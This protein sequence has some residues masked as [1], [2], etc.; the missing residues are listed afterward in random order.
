MALFTEEEIRRYAFP[1]VVESG[2]RCYKRKRVSSIH[3]EG[4][5]IITSVR[6]NGT[7]RVVVSREKGNIRFDCTCGFS[8]GGACEHVVASMYAANADGAIQIGI[9]WGSPVEEQDEVDFDT[10]ADIESWSVPVAVDEPEEEP[11]DDDELEEEPPSVVDLPIG[12]PMG[13]LYL[14]ER[15][16]MLLVELRF[17]YHDG[18]TEFSR[19]DS[20]QTRLV[21]SEDG[22]VYRVSRSRARETVMTASLA[23]Y[24]LTQYQTGVFTPCDDPRIWTLQE[25]P[26]LARDGF[27]IFGQENLRSSNARKAAP[28]MSVAVSSKEGLFDCNVQISFDGISATLASLIHAVR[29]GSRFVLLS[30]GSSGML[31]QVWLEKFAALFSAIDAENGMQSLSIRSSQFALADM[32]YE[33]ADEKCG[34]EAFLTRRDALRSFSSMDSQQPPQGFLASMRPYQLAGYEW[35]YFLKKYHFGGCLADDMGLGKTVQTIAL[36]LNEKKTDSPKP[37]LVVVPTSLIFNWQREAEKFAPE[38]NVL[39]YHGSGRLKYCDVMNMA[40]VVIT[41]YGTVI[42]DVEELKTRHFHYVILDE[43]QAIKNP[44]SQVS[45]AL[46]Q[47]SANH[48]LA[49]SGTPIENSLSELWALF[50]FLNPGMLGSFRM[51]AKNFIKPIERDLNDNTSAVL[52]KLI[53]PFILRRTKQQ[54]AN[55]LPPKNEMVLYAEM[56]PRQ[57]TLYDI[58]RD[59][60]KGKIIDSINREGMEGSRMQILEGLLRLRQICCHP[61]MVDPSFAGD[62]GKFRL[63]EQSL[64]D[65]VSEGHRVLL[66]SQFVKGLELV[67]E[68]IA[69]QGIQSEML[70]GST[71]DRGAV[72]DRFQNGEGAPVFLISL[73]AGGTGLNLTRADYVIH[74]D[75]WWN[76]SAE[77]QASDRA[78]RIGQTRTVF[79]YKMITKDSIEERVL[80]LQEQKKQ[81]VQSVI[82]TES[83]FFKHLTRDDVLGLLD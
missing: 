9:D 57:K 43:A 44:A 76:P 65:I 12:K 54:V 46:R 23:T 25:L 34:D 8:Y 49:L 51:F 77:N 16:T 7:H 22:A 72:V 45:R 19:S 6:E 26:R 18:L 67:K 64:V 83:S 20:N 50:T 32:L 59:I 71:R 11:S 21:P 60:Y 13:R 27:E 68:R 40:D 33:M 42:R 31:P 2:L 15:D 82:Q 4:E 28:K 55:D 74:L 63:L 56:L 39:I 78:Y 48:K 69:Q 61:A 52:R 37:S 79:V 70:T 53:F 35:F 36:L 10:E 17:A 81:L 29:Q 1:A 66:F 75:P 47:L 41:S 80:A 58:T 30:D 24:E 3:F 5:D 62:S 14:S 73:K 38:L